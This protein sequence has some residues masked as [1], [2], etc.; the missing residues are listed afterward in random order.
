[1]GIA[2]NVRTISSKM[3]RINLAQLMR[4]NLLAVAAVLIAG[5]CSESHHAALEQANVPAM[6]E[7]LVYLASDLYCGPLPRAGTKAGEWAQLFSDVR[8]DRRGED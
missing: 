3:K 6:K 5:G 1:M 7:T 2:E 4:A 8:D